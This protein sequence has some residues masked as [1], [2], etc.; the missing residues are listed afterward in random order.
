VQIRH[1]GGKN[2]TL[3]QIQNRSVDN[4]IVI[5]FSACILLL[6]EKNILFKMRFF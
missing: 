1:K 4:Y 2:K 3:S 5:N 6:Q